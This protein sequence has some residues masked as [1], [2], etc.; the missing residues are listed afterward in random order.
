MWRPS[1]FARLILYVNL[2]EVAQAAVHRHI[3]KIDA[4]DL[5]HFHQLW[6][7]VHAG[8]RCCYGSLVAG[9]DALEVLQVFGLGRSLDN[10]AGEGS[11]A[12]GVELAFE[13]LV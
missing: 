12:Q 2:A 11:L 4:L 9:K 6:R 13:L 10:L 3:G 8:G 5:H 1:S 7:E